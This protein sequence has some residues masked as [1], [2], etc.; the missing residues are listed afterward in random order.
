[1]KNIILTAIFLISCILNAQNLG[2]QSNESWIVRRIDLNEKFNLGLKSLPPQLIASFCKKELNA[3]YPKKRDLA[4]EFASF[5]H[6]FGG[7]YLD[8][9]SIPSTLRPCAKSYCNE[10]DPFLL[11]CFG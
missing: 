5:L 2:N 1:M 9:E 10:I 4:V 11:A 7:Y 3:Y 6:H 8:I